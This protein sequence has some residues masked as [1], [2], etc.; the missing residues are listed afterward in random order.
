MN[1]PVFLIQSSPKAILTATAVAVNEK[2]SLDFDQIIIL[3][4]NR[5]A[6]SL[7]L[8]NC[9]EIFVIDPD[10]TFQ[11]IEKFIVKNN[12]NIYFWYTDPQINDFNKRIIKKF[13]GDRLKTCS[14]D[15][16]LS[17]MKLAQYE[18][19]FHIRTALF[20]LKTKGVIDPLAQRIICSLKMA[21]EKELKKETVLKLLLLELLTNETNREIEELLEESA[22]INKRLRDFQCYF[23]NHS[24]LG[25]I[26]VI[27]PPE[28]VPSEI[29]FQQKNGH[30]GLAIALPNGSFDLLLSKKASRKIIKEENL[31]EKKGSSRFIVNEAFLFQE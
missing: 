13:V 2:I 12:K 20:A 22:K 11:E 28:N 1:K 30:D 16:Y 24:E 26:K 27:I 29:L 15:R 4:L 10:N 23:I 18:K 17:N 25:V 14:L 21:E 7:N 5:E 31:L 9:P 8:K 19:I 3:D 6:G